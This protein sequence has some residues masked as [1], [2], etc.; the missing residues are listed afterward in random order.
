METSTAKPSSNDNSLALF[1][2]RITDSIETNSRNQR[3]VPF[4]RIS[5][6]ITREV[7]YQVLS[8]L[9][10]VHFYNINKY[11]DVVVSKYLRIFSILCLVGAADFLVEYFIQFRLDDTRLPLLDEQLSGLEPRIAKAF[12]LEQYMFLTPELRRGMIHQVFD[13]KIVLP[14]TQEEELLSQ[15]AFG[16][17]YK[18]GV[19]EDYQKLVQP[20]TKVSIKM[21]IVK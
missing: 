17:V 10:T 7:I 20:H 11:I 1:R 15:G 8:E 19:H 9:K 16:R 14:F 6:L 21:R 4:S 3:F 18:A 13:D 5:C 2:D 12:K